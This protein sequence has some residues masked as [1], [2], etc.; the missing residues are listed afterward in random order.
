MFD[1]RFMP[2]F[3]I[4][5]LIIVFNPNGPKGDT[6]KKMPI[7]NLGAIL[8]EK[9]FPKE[10]LFSIHIIIVVR[11]HPTKFMHDISNPPPRHS[12]LDAI[13]KFM[14]DQLTSIGR[15]KTALF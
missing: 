5:N 12:S 3:M 14:L 13:P 11:P 15:T 7:F 1:T 6:S 8:L 9:S 10:S 4:K 2:L